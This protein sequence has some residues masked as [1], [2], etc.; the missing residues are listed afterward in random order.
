VDIFTFFICS[1]L[2]ILENGK[3]DLYIF[4]CFN[5]QL[6][7]TWLLDGG[8]TGEVS[9]NDIDRVELC[10][11]LLS[12]K[13]STY[14]PLAVTLREYAFTLLRGLSLHALGVTALSEDIAAAISALV[15][16]LGMVVL[17]DTSHVRH[18]AS[19][20]GDAFSTD[21]IGI[22]RGVLQSLSPFIADYFVWLTDH[23]KPFVR[24]C[25]ALEV[26]EHVHPALRKS[27]RD[28]EFSSP[29]DIIM[30][31]EG[32]YK[33]HL[34]LMSL[35]IQLFQR[36]DIHQVCMYVC[37]YVCSCFCFCSYSLLCFLKLLL[38]FV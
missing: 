33:R 38:Q 29:A 28:E 12:S 9:G 34:T 19:A 10:V 11:A 1:E 31:Y 22:Q 2:S 6:T 13:C 18:T 14:S 8:G 21:V 3:H 26:V 7:N 23:K 36:E 30:K 37:M 16:H 17:G 5:N 27:L 20:A 15:H 25:R 35:P 32:K 24:I 4:L